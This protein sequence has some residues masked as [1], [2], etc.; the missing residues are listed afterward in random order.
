MQ[1]IETNKIYKH[2][3]AFEST[4]D[5]LKSNWNI[6]DSS[7]YISY[8]MNEV[9]AIEL[10]FKAIINFENNSKKIPQTHHLDEL[11]NHLS[12]RSKQSIIKYFD[13]AVFD[14]DL[15]QIEAMYNL[16]LTK[17]LVSLLEHY[18]NIFVKVRYLYE[19]PLTYPVL[20]LE[21]LRESVKKRCEELDF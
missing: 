2:A 3:L 7:L 18:S 9:F 6:L 19:S 21:Q 5:V 1:L 13:S 14:S 17:D 8:F 16:T 4:A 20:F 12:E 10:F 15:N 11:Y